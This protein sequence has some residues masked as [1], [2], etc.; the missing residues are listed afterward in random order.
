MIGQ[1]TTWASKGLSVSVALSLILVF[2]VACG[3][4]STTTTGGRVTTPI[5]IGIA[6]SLSGDFAD[7]GKALEQGYQ[8]W[9]DEVN[10]HGGLLGRQVKLDIVDDASNPDQVQISYQKL[11]TAEK[12]DLIF[13]PFSTQQTKPASLVASQ[14]GYAMLEGSGGG[15]S[16]FNRGLH[17]VFDVSLP[18][19]NDLVSF[20]HY[21]LAL[22]VSKR[23]T[24]AA[25]ITEDDPF[26]QPQVDRA[27]EVL[28]QGGVKTLS[29]QVYPS[30]GSNY[31]L[32][33]DTV[34]ISHAQVVVCGTELPDSSAFIKHFELLHY[35][36]RM[37]VA[38]AGPD[39]GHAFLKAIGGSESAEGIFF[40]NGWYP[41]LK[42]PGNTDMIKAYLARYKGTSDEI[43]ADIAE[44]YSVGQVAFQATTKIKSLDNAKL[45]AELHSGD[46]FQSVQGPVK[47]DATGQNILAQAYL[48]Q[49]QKGTVIPVYPAS[50]ALVAPEF[51]KPNW[52]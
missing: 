9:A 33:A 1:G 25:Y 11:I 27:R 28:E 39:Q 45:L 37:L 24:T 8:L 41:Q 18:V 23:P 40:P 16:V 43:S 12:V 47:F 4:Q 7:D 51:P 5:K 52:P 34:A 2:G 13:G 49:W 20:A 30:G 42:T 10:A 6:L 22:P 44:A 38:T 19:V 36:P 29:S 17:N 15:P 31:N 26:T 3:S 21:L 14:Y 46:T 50:V 48:F 35:N 32:I